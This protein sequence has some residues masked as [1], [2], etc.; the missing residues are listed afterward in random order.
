[1]RQKILISVMMLIVASSINAC[2]AIKK[3][4]NDRVSTQKEWGTCK[5]CG[6]TSCKKECVS[7]IK[8]DTLQIKN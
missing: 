4:H 3:C 6:S 8:S 2:T 7:Q 1:M 5:T